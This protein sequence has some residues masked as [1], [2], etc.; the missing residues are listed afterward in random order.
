MP[1]K[2]STAAQRA[3]E[4][5]RQGGKYT[6]ALRAAEGPAADVTGPDDRFGGHEFEYESST[7][8]FRCSECRVYEVVARDTDG[9]IKPCTGLVGYGGDTERVYLLLTENPV[10]PCSHAAQLASSVRGT[11]IG[12]APRFSW[13]DGRLLVESAP[14]VVD[15]LT[16]RIELITST[17]DGKQ[18]PTVASVDRLTE[19]AGRALLAENYAAYVAKYGTPA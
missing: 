10:L 1:K 18:V 13:R 14:S 5:A 11:G 2:Q 17:V 15:E 8:L 12:R 16:R 6:E 9:P 7:D 19:E 3:R 4:A